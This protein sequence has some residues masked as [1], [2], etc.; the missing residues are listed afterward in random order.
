MDLI[1]EWMNKLDW[2]ISYILSIF[3]LYYAEIFFL[4][5]PQ[6][7]SLYIKAQ[8][9]SLFLNYYYF[10]ILKFFI[11]LSNALVYHHGNGKNNYTHS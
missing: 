5:Y 1:I 7:N 6:F 10:S 3:K 9:Q 2:D 11:S 8:T 4:K